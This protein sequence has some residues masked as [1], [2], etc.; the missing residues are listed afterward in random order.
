MSRL[1]AQTPADTSAALV[2]DRA[3]IASESTIAL[4]FR[5]TDVNRKIR[6]LASSTTIMQANAITWSIVSAAPKT[7]NTRTGAGASPGA[8]S[9][10]VFP[11]SS[12]VTGGMATASPMVATTFT[13]SVARRSARNSTSHSAI[14]S[15]GPAT[16]IATRA[17]AH[18][19]QPCW[20]FRK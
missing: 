3:V 12:A 18:I 4:T 13:S 6:A 2:P 19:D 1:A 15:A 5:P 16:R 20:E 11:S 17:A 10:W 14:P 7:W 8:A 9:I